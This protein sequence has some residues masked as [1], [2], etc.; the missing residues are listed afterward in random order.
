MDRPNQY[1]SPTV[2]VPAKK[3]IF[4]TD[5]WTENKLTGDW[6]GLRNKMAEYGLAL[7]ILYAAVIMQNSHG[8]FDS[9]MVGGGPLGITAT[10]DTENLMGLKGGT[11]FVDWEFYNWYNQRYAPEDTFDPSGSYV[12]VNTNFIDSDDSILNQL[13]QLYYR[14][15]FMDDQLALTLGKMDANAPFVSVEAAGAFQNSISMFTPTLNAF[16]PTYPNESTAVMGEISKSDFFTFKAALFD[17]TSAAY[18]AS[19]GVTGPATGPRGPETFFHN[20]GHWWVVAQMD[21]NWKINEE[22]SGSLGL[23][24]W[25]QTGRVAT[26]GLDQA[27]VSDVPGWYIQ[28]QQTLWALNKDLAQDGG[29]LVFFGQFG[30]SDPDKNPV[31]WSLMTGFS[32]TGFMP[33]RPAD[34]VGVMFAYSKFT[35]NPGIYQSTQRNGSPGSTGGA[36]SSIEAYYIAQWTSWSYLQPGVMWIHTPGGGDPAPLRDDILLYVVLGINF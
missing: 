27:G 16:I 25:I 2:K 28:W 35:E 29:G 22:L 36:E 31:H 10:V 11:L 14:Q 26:Q 15:S 32:A 6:A 9:G 34:S 24:G 19:T 30:W 7:D 3:E 4:T 23:G 12:G 18:D 5:A 33:K 20:D 17:G 13:A 8:G 21:F 1:P